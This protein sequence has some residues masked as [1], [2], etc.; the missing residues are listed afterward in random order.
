MTLSPAYRDKIKEALTV[1]MPIIAGQLGQV[2][3]GFFD[4]VQIGGLGPEYI[5]ASGF[6]NGIYWMTVLLGMGILFAVSPLVS[7][8]F[9]EGKGHK[10]IGVLISSLVVSVVLAVVFMVVMWFIKEN[11][12]ILK[13]S[14]TD[15]ILGA[16]FLRIVNWSTGFIFLFMA[17]KQFLDGMERTRIGMY[18]TIGGLLLNI[19][20]N[21]ILIY[22]AF[23]IPQLGIEGA[24]IAT[25]TARIAMTIAILTFIWRDEKVRELRREFIQYSDPALSYIKPILIIGI[26]AGLQFFWEVAAFNAGQ[27]MSGWISMKAE[28]AHMIAIGLASITFMVA[29]G[30]SAAG[31]IMVG[32]SYGAKDKEGIRI[33]GNTVFILTVVFEVVFALMFLTCHNL[34]PKLYTGDPAVIAIASTMLILAAVFQISDGLQAAAAGALRGMQDVKFPAVIAFVSYWII[35]I[36]ACY[37]LS[38]PAHGY[39]LNLGLKGIWIGFIIGLSVA[40]VMQLIRFRML[41][42]KKELDPP[43]G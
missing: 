10:S 25:T 41:L 39:G 27:I 1:A 9:G 32:Y 30:L 29:T 8:A 2:L 43:L 4:T 6:A 11:L 23:G 26:P 5:A 28:A 15:N 37:L 42:R 24:A 3:M 34:L 7:E 13:H 40:A 22:G 33:A 21:R 16:K 35:M 31:T 14:D 36:P 18:I 17:G 20:L 38:F 12:P 19:V